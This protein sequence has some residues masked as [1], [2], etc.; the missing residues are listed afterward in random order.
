MK[1]YPICIL[2][3]IVTFLAYGQSRK[4]SPS[5]F[6]IGVGDTLTLFAR[7]S[8]CGE[9][10][11]RHEYLRIYRDESLVV[12]YSKDSVYCG[13]E[14]EITRYPPQTIQKKLTDSDLDIIEA[15]IKKVIKLSKK[16]QIYGGNANNG[17]YVTFR[18]QELFCIDSFFVWDE[19]DKMTKRV[20]Q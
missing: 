19:F 16:E 4:R 7:Y 2:L 1:K 11:G 18:Q 5:I 20:F 6:S 8:E 12:D 9:W 13:R 3:F 14:I 17:F 10:G 15:Y